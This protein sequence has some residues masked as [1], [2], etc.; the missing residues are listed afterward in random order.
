MNGCPLLTLLCLSLLQSEL[1]AD[2]E[3]RMHEWS[4][5][6]DDNE[7]EAVVGAE[8]QQWVEQVRGL[9]GWGEATDRRGMT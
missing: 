9:G 2:R 1:E 4:A 5:T 3:R 6:G 7:D 8:L